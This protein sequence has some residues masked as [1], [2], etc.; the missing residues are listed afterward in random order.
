LVRAGKDGVAR[1]A[2]P[3]HRGGRPIVMPTAR[4]KLHKLGAGAGPLGAGRRRGRA[5]NGSVANAAET[6]APSAGVVDRLAAACALAAGVV[7]RAGVAA[8]CV[9]SADA[10]GSC[11]AGQVGSDAALAECA[12]CADVEC[13]SGAGR[14][15]SDA[16]HASRDAALAECGGLECNP[17]AAPASRDAEG[18]A[19]GLDAPVSAAGPV[20]A[21]PT[22]S[23]G[24]AGAPSRRGRLPRILLLHAH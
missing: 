20:L 8:E 18:P 4:T 10:G 24:L 21:G 17:D 5:N 3:P 13:S 22:R 23:G 7:C 15:F 6:H 14:A 12:A 1:E 9:T 11:A 19:S 2:D 16:A